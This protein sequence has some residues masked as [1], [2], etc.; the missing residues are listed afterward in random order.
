MSYACATLKCM[1]D[2]CRQLYPWL[3]TFLG[4]QTPSTQLQPR[5][6]E[7]EFWQQGAQL[8]PLAYYGLLE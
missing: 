8:G 5:Q 2:L 4:Y 7:I 3:A 6:M 1:F